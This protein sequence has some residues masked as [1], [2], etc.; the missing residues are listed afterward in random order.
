MI[1]LPLATESWD[2]EEYNAIKK[3]V[4]SGH[5]TMGEEVKK[6]EEKFAE[7]FKVKYA[8]M[9]NSGSSAN[10]LAI[11][12][13]IYSNK[14]NLSSGDEVIVP[15][16]S[17]AT[18]YSP[19]QQ[20]NLKVKFVD[21]DLDTLNFNIDE[22]KKAITEKTKL[23]FAVN[24]LGNSNEY[25]EILEICKEKKII[26]IE[27][28]CEA[29][30]AKYKDKYLGTIGVMGTFSMFFSHHISTMEG[31]IIVTDD[32]E[33]RDIMLCIRAHGW[34]RNLDSNSLIYQ[35]KEDDFY[36]MFNFILP[37]YNLRPLELEG[38]LGIEQ[39]KKLP[40][41]ID[42]RRKNAEF[43]VEKFSQL[44]SVIIQKEIGE[45][46]YF[47][48]SLIISPKSKFTRNELVDILRNEKVECR[49]IVAGNFTRNEVIKYFNYEIFG[50]LKNADYLHENGLF[51][52]NHHYSCRK[53]IEQI[54]EIIKNMEY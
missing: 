40:K 7:Y 39:I 14:Y 3:V 34:T 5:F 4:N 2:K 42:E 43:F 49:P 51:I 33:L 15:A 36:E 10:L 48:F 25:D 21:I 6:F 50:K 22:L 54:Y 45:S 46:S 17:W 12:A 29:M 37:G 28:N 20:Y 1:K 44:K 52:G 23:I 27:D 11:A 38:A 41:I 18:T 19:L 8:V 16:V 30:G 53:E 32:K 47:G 35:K 31:G 9:V 24:L 26:L 13:L